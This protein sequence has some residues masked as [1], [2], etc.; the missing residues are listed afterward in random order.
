MTT[1]DDLIDTLSAAAHDGW[2]ASKLEQGITSRCSETGEE[3]MVPY[4]DLSEPAKDLDRT[5]VRSILDAIDTAGYAVLSRD[6]Y[7]EL[8]RRPQ[9]IQ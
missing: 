7:A 5:A 1:R 6:R 8:T 4:A 2:M 9:E 3:L